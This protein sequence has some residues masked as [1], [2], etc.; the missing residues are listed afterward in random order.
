MTSP[1]EAIR[2]PDPYPY[3]ATLTAERPFTYDET[4]G[5]W[6]ASDAAAV[7]AALRSGALRVRP[8]A[9]PVPAGIVGTP[10]GEVFGSLVR[11]TD[12]D[13]QQRLKGVVVEALGRADT[14]AAAALAARLT[15]ASLAASPDPRLT[16]LMFGVPAR[17]VAGL[18][19]L[20]AG[21][22]EEAARLIGDFVQCIP[23][24]ATAAQQQ[25]AARA[26][27]GLQELMGPRL[28]AAEAG[29]GLLHDL[30]RA[31]QRADWPDTA[32]LLANAV[33]FLSQTYDA[34][35][36]LIGNVLVALARGEAV[37][38]G[39]D[40]L[41]QLAREVVRHD[42]P[43][44]NTRRF[45][46]EPF[47][48]G[49]AEVAPPDRPCCCSSR[50]PTATPPPTPTRTPSGPDAPSLPC[51]PS[52][53]PP[54]AAPARTWRWPSPPR[55]PPSCSAPA[56]TR[57]RCPPG[58]TTGRRP[59]PGSPPPLI[60]RSSERQEQRSRCPTRHDCGCGMRPGRPSA[61]PPSCPRTQRCWWS[62]ESRSPSRSRPSASSRS[63]TTSP[64]A[65]GPHRLGS[66]ADAPA[67]E[68]VLGLKELP[69]APAELR[70]RHIFFGHAYKGQARRGGAAPALHRRRRRPARPRIPRGRRRPTARRLRILGR[71]H[72][73][74]PRRAPSPGGA[75]HAA[76]PRTKEELDG[77]LRASRDAAQPC[78][79]LVIGALG[80]C[81]QGARDALTVAGIEPTCWDLAETRN[82]DKAALLAHDLLVNTVLTTR[83]VPPFLTGADLDDP[84]RRLSVVC[85]V[86][87]DVTSDCNVLP[88]YDDVTDWER[89]V[90][91]LREGDVPVDL[92]AIDNL[93]SLLP[94]EASRAF[95]AELLPQLLELDGPA[96]ERCLNDFRNA[97]G[98]HDE[99]NA[100]V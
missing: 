73:R 32:A 59:T 66:W 54:T 16:E 74:R 50:P 85:D 1:I 38:P 20:D 37:P 88:V 96:W 28:A 4:V 83:P 21:A 78:T 47:R 13:L 68:Y 31:A 86:T 75:E 92:I 63:A 60:L 35:A 76:H 6:V 30:V 19:G 34:T 24:S 9:E 23:A 10:A 62:A 71:I 70:H 43:I 7:T 100:R 22:D 26:A 17:V 48:H 57:P 18:C 77:A 79:A 58:R 53:P 98:L 55:S 69:E 5:A 36:G 82:L 94:A 64:P 27:A 44:Q 39:D 15:R 42:A 12:G 56:G 25:A 72:R 45:A 65:A 51:S 8:P 40:G 81:G 90:R 52:G 41:A 84:A 46:A 89:P 14:T 29:N 3:Y 99:E 2:L 91:R 95:S 11:M 80:R 93:P 67:G 87:C 33:G 49:D 61:V 97:A